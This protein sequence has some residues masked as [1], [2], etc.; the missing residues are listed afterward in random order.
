MDSIDNFCQIYQFLASNHEIRS[1]IHRFR[2]WPVIFIPENQKEGKFIFVQ[3]TFWHDPLSLLSSQPTSTNRISLESYYGNNTIL[4]S[5]F[6]EVLGV[7]YQ[8]TMDDYI[9]LLSNVHENDTLWQVIQ[10]A[11][12]LTTEQDKHKEVRRMKD[13]CS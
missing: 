9:P 5:F 10:V 1:L 8:P 12:K 7:E 4:Q 13:F 2:L 11:T 3:Q 6:L